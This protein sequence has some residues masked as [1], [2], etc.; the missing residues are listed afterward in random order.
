MSKEKSSARDWKKIYPKVAFVKAGKEDEGYM[1]RLAAKEIGIVPQRLRSHTNL[2]IHLGGQRIGFISYRRLPDNIIYIY[3]FVLE[4]QCQ[5]RGYAQPVILKLIMMEREK[6]PLEGINFRIHKTNQ[7]A[8][9]VALEKYGY[10]VIKEMPK[11]LVLFKPYPPD[12]KPV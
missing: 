2:L 1:L 3:L 9:H 6:Q 10:K 11:H 5:N 4:E 8:L 7:Q 12:Y